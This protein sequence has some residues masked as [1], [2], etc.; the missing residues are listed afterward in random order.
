M[1]FKFAVAVGTETSNFPTVKFAVF[2]KSSWFSSVS[3]IVA[4]TVYEP[5]SVGFVAVG[6][7][8]VPAFVVPEYEYVTV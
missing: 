2:T 8:A 7:Y 4:V 1:Y 3:E 6:P 5:A